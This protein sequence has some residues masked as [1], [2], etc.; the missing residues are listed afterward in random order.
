MNPQIT[1]YINNKPKEQ[2]DILNAIRSLL[3][4][5]VENVMDEFKWSRPVF[6]LKKD[7]AYLQANK[8]HVTLGFYI[9][10]EKLNDSKGLLERTGNTMRHIKIRKIEDIDENLLKEWFEIVTQD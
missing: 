3:H 10:L 6:K 2:Q 4:Q 9:D 7:F 8:N 1:E 5:S